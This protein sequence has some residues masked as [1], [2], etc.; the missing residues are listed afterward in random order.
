MIQAASNIFATAFK[1]DMQMDKQIVKKI[2]TGVKPER[3]GKSHKIII[4]GQE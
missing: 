1:I 4:E 2:A 3:K